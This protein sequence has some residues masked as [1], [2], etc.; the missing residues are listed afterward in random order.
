MRTAT[1]GNTDNNAHKRLKNIGASLEMSRT[2]SISWN[3]AL[4]APIPNASD[5]T[6]TNPKA[7]FCL[8]C[9]TP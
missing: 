5:K 9:R 6:A 3:I 2:A 1:E 8:S 4:F 7:G